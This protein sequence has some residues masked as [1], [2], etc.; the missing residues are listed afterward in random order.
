MMVLELIACWERK[1]MVVLVLRNDQGDRRK[2]ADELQ[3]NRSEIDG[4]D[5]D[6]RR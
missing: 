6:T 3:R 2:G 4:G 1:E 5:G